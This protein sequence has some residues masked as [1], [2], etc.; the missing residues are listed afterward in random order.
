MFMKKLLCLFMSSVVMLA[1]GCKKEPKQ[2]SLMINGVEGGGQTAEVVF[3]P[4]GGTLSIDIKSNTSWAITA[5]NS[6]WYE[7]SALNGKGDAKVNVT[8]KPNSGDTE[9]RAMI[10]VTAG[11]ATAAVSLIQKS[12]TLP[13]T[14]KKSELKVR[15]YGGD[16][17]VEV[18]KG[19]DM[20]VDAGCGW[21]K[22][23]M[24]NKEEGTVTLSFAENGTDQY[25]EAD[26]KIVTAS[27]KKVLATVHVSQSWR[28]I[29]PG[30]LLIEE[31]YFTGTALPKTGRPEKHN[32]DQYYKLTNN[33]DETLYAD[34]VVIMESKI[35]SVIKVDYEV[36]IKDTHSGIQTAYRIPGNGRDVPVKPG[37]SLIIANNAQNHT[38]ENPDSFDLSNADF[39]WYDKSTSY[40]N[41]DIDN[42]KVPNLD[43]WYTYSLSYWVLHNRGYTGHAIAI[44]P[45]SVTKEKFLADYKWTGSYYIPSSSGSS[46]KM[47]ISKA[48]KIPNEWVLDAVNLSLKQLFYTLPFSE[49]LDAGYT[50]CGNKDSDPKRYGKSVRRKRG[51]DGKLADTNN[52]ASDFIPNSVPSLKK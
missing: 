50:Y 22:G 28:N 32:G 24:I 19:M 21:I 35:N 26:V 1:I 2:D 30:E 12:R 11:T 41:P 4:E 10:N 52:S 14:P 40:T 9:R 49:K 37:K 16:K 23:G 45:K 48:Y 13:S 39:E 51:A 47:E 36:P 25:R 8:A 42:P 29:E 7:L 15:A 3:A 38:L 20:S 31:I 6:D 34:G 33:T 43:V 46:Y 27:S 18:V 5:D 44:F 17:I